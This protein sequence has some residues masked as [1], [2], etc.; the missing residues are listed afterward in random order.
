MKQIVQ[1]NNQK[2]LGYTE[3]INYIKKQ[4]NGIYGLCA[5]ELAEG[6]AYNGNVY[7]LYD[8]GENIDGDVVVVVDIDFGKIFEKINTTNSIAFV[9]L[10]EDSKIDEVTASEHLELF[11][12]FKENVSCKVGQIRR[13]KDKLY[14]CIQEHTSSAEW[15]PDVATSLWLLIGDPDEEYPTWAQPVGSHDAYMKGDRVTHDSKKYVSTV[16]YNVWQPGV[17]GWEL[18]ESEG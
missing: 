5:E 10:A 8:K 1:V 3:K 15:T 6:I 18:V 4:A 11:E 17:Y 13:Y 9:T 2:V 7:K 14:K 12:E 16:D